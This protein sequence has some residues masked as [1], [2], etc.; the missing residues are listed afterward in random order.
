MNLMLPFARGFNTVSGG[1]NQYEIVV[2]LFAAYA[3][4]NKGTIILQLISLVMDSS[5]L[6]KLLGHLGT[7]ATW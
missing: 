1:L 2:P 6:D 5:T 4:P 3:A 7:Y